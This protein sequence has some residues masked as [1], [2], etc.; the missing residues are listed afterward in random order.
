MVS[1]H[2]E[3]KQFITPGCTV[4]NIKMDIRKIW[5]DNVRTFIWIGIACTGA[6]VNME[7]NL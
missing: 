7:V 1:E 4:N 2:V 6:L 3:K 5:L